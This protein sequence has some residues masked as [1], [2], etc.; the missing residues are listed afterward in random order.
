MYE[1]GL[2]GLL[3]HACAL[4]N[5]FCGVLGI[6][7]R[8]HSR[9]HET[10]ASSLKIYIQMKQVGSGS[11]TAVPHSPN[12]ACLH[13]HMQ[14]CNLHVLVLQSTRLNRDPDTG[15]INA[16]VLVAILVA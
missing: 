14:V 8:Y 2:L 15:T 16:R 7:R 10:L 11:G 9:D 3:E 6:N 13:M 12:H 5:R 4:C 1:N